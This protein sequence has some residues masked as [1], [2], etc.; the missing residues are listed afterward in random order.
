MMQRKT[1]ARERDKSSITSLDDLY[2]E[3]S[4]EQLEEEAELHSEERHNF[5][6]EPNTW[7]VVQTDPRGQE[8]TLTRLSPGGDTSL[9]PSD[10][11]EALGEHYNIQLGFDE[12]AISSLLETALASP[13]TILNLNQVIARAKTP[14][15]GDDARIKWESKLSEDR[16]TEA[17]Q[18]HAALKLQ[19]L[20][21][22]M[23]CNARG[24]LVLPDQ[25]LAHVLPETEGEPGRNI[26][27]EERR[28]P[29]RPVSLE[30]GENVRLE[31]DKI[32]AGA[33]G[34]V[35][36]GEGVLSI[37]PPIWIAED[38][39]R[40]VY[41]HMVLFEKPPLPT[42]DAVRSLLTESKVTYGINNRAIEKLCSK[43]L[44]PRR[45]RVLT[46]ARGG[47]PMNGEDTRIEYTF[48]PEQRA[49]KI[50]PDGSIDFG[51]RN[52]VIGVGENELLA[53][54]HPAT[55]GIAGYTIFNEELAATDG[56]EK[57][58]KAGDN[59]RA[60]GDPPAKFFAAVDGNAQVSG[61]VIH[62]KPIYVI[63]GDVDYETGNIDVATDV[64]IAGNV[65]AGFTV[66]SRGSVT[67]SGSVESGATVV[68]AGDVIVSQGIVG[69]QTND[70]ARGILSMGTIQCKFIQT[71]NVLAKEA[72]E[73]GSYIFNASVR[74]GGEITVRSGGGERG[75]SIV[76][77]EVFA[78][79]SIQAKNIGSSTTAGTVIG[80][81][82]D[83]V[84]AIK[85]ARL[86][87]ERLKLSRTIELQLRALGLDV[88]DT[89]RIK[90]VQY[91]T[92]KSRRAHIAQIVAKLYEAKELFDK[93]EADIKPLA[94]KNAVVE[95]G[96]NIE[97]AGTIYPG[98][99]VHVGQS[100]LAVDKDI[101]RSRFFQEEGAVSHKS[102]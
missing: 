71:A 83:P 8:A 85:L 54:V 39:L 82:S 7:M 34:Y 70:T 60:E 30:L 74:C 61:D 33:Y 43:Q 59:V 56:E 4:G 94:K 16:L 24:I 3:R 58:Y 52:L 12:E 21:A 37:A 35:G 20:E 9:V 41:C 80:L 75:G 45:K 72:I 64:Q 95:E 26:F 50:M 101:R 42:E 62:V 73:V 23:K 14:V 51:H 40:A 48:D 2:L 28:V 47:P 53:T 29:G 99:E 88:I 22:A 1:R 57:V 19:P 76:G 55:E 18:I 84:T 86:R 38:S 44:S 6:T 17:F 93:V 79:R 11:I 63:N 65:R 25:V 102:L 92:P 49:G 69:E 5:G 77:G 97:I 68:A 96:A 91:N 89:E 10:L 87:K 90:A 100:V 78:A 98:A 15:P 13:D 27:G 46:L 31:D 81:N 66:E 67:V 32:I 36:I